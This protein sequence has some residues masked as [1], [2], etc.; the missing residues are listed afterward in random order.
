MTIAHTGDEVR[1]H[2]KLKTAQGER[3]IEESWTTDGEEREFSPP[4][5]LEGS[6]GKRKAYW[7]PGDRA[8]VVAEDTLLAGPNGPTTQQTTR[9][10]TL[11]RRW[12]DPDHRLLPGHSQRILRIAPRLQTVTGYRLSS[13]DAGRPGASS[14]CVCSQ[15]ELL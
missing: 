5:A 10:L 9:K 8:L 6:K 14:P 2:A 15:V 3:A 13:G 11:F 12:H 7:L 4:G 1:V